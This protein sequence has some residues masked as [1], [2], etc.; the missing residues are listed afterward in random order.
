MRNILSKFDFFSFDLDK[1]WKQD[2]ITVAGGNGFGN[3]SNQ[4][5]FP[6]NIVIDDD[7]T[8]YIADSSNHRIVEWKSNATN[9]QILAGGNETNQLNNPIDV[10]IDKENNSLIICDRFNNR[11]MQWPRQKN[12]TNG[13]IFISDIFCWGL[14][15]DQ[16]GSLCLQLDEL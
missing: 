10:I 16:D 12:S 4:L 2:G 14:A 6:S 13:Y 9:G 1:K 11:V 3:K 8:I 5:A 7:Q 15:M